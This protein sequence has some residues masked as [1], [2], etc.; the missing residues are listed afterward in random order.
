MEKDLKEIQKEI[1]TK[2]EKVIY[3]REETLS[4][5]EKWEE[6]AREILELEEKLNDRQY[7]DR[8]SISG[9]QA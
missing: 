2:L 5:L 4:N 8:S 9:G 3:Y 7:Q 6:C 1:E